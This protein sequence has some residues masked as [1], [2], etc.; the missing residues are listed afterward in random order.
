MQTDEIKIP[1][2]ITSKAKKIT[3][4]Y[5][6]PFTGELTDR[7]KYVHFTVFACP[8][9]RAIKHDSFDSLLKQIIK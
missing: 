3:D 9:E 7:R 4:G 6:N 5:K 8:L 2:W 1:E